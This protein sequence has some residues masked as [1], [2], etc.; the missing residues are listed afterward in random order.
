M[1]KMTLEEWRGTYVYPQQNVIDDFKKF[2]NVDI[3]EEIEAVLLS[4]YKNY[5]NGVIIHD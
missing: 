4:E 3:L 2:H 5:C 1:K